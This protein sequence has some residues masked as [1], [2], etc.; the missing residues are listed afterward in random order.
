MKPKTEVNVR[1]PLPTIWLAVWI[2]WGCPQLATWNAWLV[3]LLVVLFL[4]VVP[5]V[6]AWKA[7]SERSDRGNRDD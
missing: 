2:M 3:S 7:F 1:I 6:S 4:H 5:D